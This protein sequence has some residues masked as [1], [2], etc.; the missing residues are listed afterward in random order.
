MRATEPGRGTRG[1]RYDAGTKGR[2]TT[3]TRVRNDDPRLDSWRSFLVAHA[4]LFR[5]L[6]DELRAEHGLSLPEYDALLAIA[7]APDRRIRMHMLAD[8][9]VLSRSGITRLVDRLVAGGLVERVS[10]TSDARGAEAA[11]TDDG[12]HRLR[13]AARTHLRGVERYFLDAIEPADL[14]VVGRALATVAERTRGGPGGPG[15]P[16][17]P[18]EPEPS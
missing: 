14:D 17:P 6:D 11:L 4:R 9:V 16:E 2:D 5:R 10:C 1:V 15:G 3:A 8:G 7:R 13:E 18:P 12:L